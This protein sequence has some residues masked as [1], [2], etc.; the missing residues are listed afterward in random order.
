M[1]AASC[2]LWGQVS[3][4]AD[5]VPCEEEERSFSKQ[6]LLASSQLQQ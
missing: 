2:S 5:R 4:L 1:G 6:R 3:S